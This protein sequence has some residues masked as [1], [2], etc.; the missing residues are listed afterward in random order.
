M[1]GSTAAESDTRP[2]RSAVST[3]IWPPHPSSD[4]WWYSSAVVVGTALFVAA[5]INQPY[6][7]NEIEQMLPYGSNDVGTMTGG[8]RQPP[9][10]PLLGALLQHVLGEGQLRQRLVPILAGVG[11]LVLLGL[12]LRRLGLGYAGAFALWMLATQPLMVRYSAYTRPYALP[13]FLS[14]L[15]TYAGHQWLVGRRKVWFVVAVGA[16]CL[17]PL[18]RVPE[19]NTFL[20]VVAAALGWFSVRGHFTWR[21]TAPLI[22]AALAAVALIGLPLFRALSSSASLFDPSPSDVASKFGGGVSELTTAVGPAMAGWFPWWPLTVAIVVAGLVVPL[23]RRRVVYEWGWVWWPLLAAPVVFL[24]AY[25]FASTT[26]FVGR[27]YRDRYAYFFCPRSSC[28]SHRSPRP[29]KTGCAT[30]WG[31]VSD[32]ACSLGPNS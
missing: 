15:F 31:C 14:M 6:N 11:T 8:T 17:L 16:A 12:F 21:Q 19:P 2:T 22:G 30:A 24:L 26:N 29:S 5:A 4:F 13:V 1:Q 28:W 9:L 25:H 20:V 32:W 18:S 23:S 3:G 27:P 10:D 7:Q